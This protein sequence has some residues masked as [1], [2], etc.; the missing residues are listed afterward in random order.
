MAPKSRPACE[1]GEGIV[2]I[3]CRLNGLHYPWAGLNLHLFFEE[4]GVYSLGLAWTTK[5]PVAVESNMPIKE[6]FTHCP[7]EAEEG[8]FVAKW[9]NFKRDF[10][11]MTD[12]VCS[13]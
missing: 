1:S 10:P 12:A 4:G 5:V 11:S 6:W 2:T 8:I 9:S 7:Y 13:K 3:R